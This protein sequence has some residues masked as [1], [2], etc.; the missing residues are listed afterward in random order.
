MAVTPLLPRG[1]PFSEVAASTAFLWRQSLAAVAAALLMFGSIGL[2]LRQ[3]ERTGRFGAIAFVLALLGSALLLATEWLQLF[4]VR[5]VAIRAPETLDRLDAA[6][7]GLDDV[8]AMAAL[9]VFVA[10]WIA[11]AVSSRRSGLFPRHA[12]TLVIAGLFATPFLSVALPPLIAGAI[13]NALLGAGFIW[14]GS[15]LARGSSRVPEI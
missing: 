15:G 4:E 10:G 14:L 8:G 9:T 3:A 11:L 7:V 6:G 2:Y 12:T 5:D 1:V 13:G